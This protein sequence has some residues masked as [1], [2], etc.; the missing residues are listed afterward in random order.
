MKD[1]VFLTNR[2][3]DSSTEL[4]FIEDAVSQ[5]K[6][7]HLQNVLKLACLVVYYGAKYLTWFFSRP[8]HK[9]NNLL[10]NADSAPDSFPVHTK[11]ANRVA[12]KDVCT[13]SNTFK[14]NESINPNGG[15]NARWFIVSVRISYLIVHL[16]K[17]NT[18]RPNTSTQ[19]VELNTTLV[20]IVQ[21]KCKSKT[22]ENRTA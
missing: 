2:V 18:S 9:C 16:N 11:P 5:K 3:I 6:T 10:K 14:K 17:T 4:M 1:W 12:K 13:A 8:L 21:P 7:T 20:S 19:F 22:V 15:P